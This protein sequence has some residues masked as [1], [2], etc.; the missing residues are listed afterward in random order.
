MYFS[1]L[2]GQAPD[3]S[4]SLE[5]RAGR[6][7]ARHEVAV[8]AEHV[9]RALAHAGHDPH[10]HR[11]VGGVRELDADLGDRRAQ[12]AHAERHH[13]QRPAA[14]RARELLVQDLAHLLRRA[15][16]VGRAGVVLVLGADERAVLDARDITRVAAGQ[17][18]VRPLG[19]R[20]LLERPRLDEL[21]AQGVVLLR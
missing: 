6:V 18:G 15:P 16:V 19:V 9:Q 17:I 8:L 3:F 7:Q 11:H 5:R 1:S 21:G 10:A 14:H 20:E 13:V 2:H 12:R 4:P